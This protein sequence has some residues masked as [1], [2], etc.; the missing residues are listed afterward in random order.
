MSIASDKLMNLGDGQVLYNDLRGRIDG[1][2]VTGPL[3]PSDTET[4]TAAHA[5]GDVITVGGVLYRVTA[6]IAVGDTIASGTNVT[7][8]TIAEELA[9]KAKAANP[10]FTGSL[11]LGSV[12]LTQAKLAEL[13]NL[14]TAAGVSY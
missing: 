10:A 9:E 6:A 2:D 5:A 3:A 13:V 7:P 11:T 8:T 12:T 1:K 4:A 14:S